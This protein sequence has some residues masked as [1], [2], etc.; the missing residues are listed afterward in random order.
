[1]CSGKKLPQSVE[2]AIRRM[3][4][5]GASY[6]TIAATLGVSTRTVG[7]VMKGGENRDPERPRDTL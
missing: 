2:R 6:R 3:A 5:A 1:M 4:R 7:R